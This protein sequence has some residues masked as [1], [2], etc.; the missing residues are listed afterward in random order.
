MDNL[1]INDYIYIVNEYGK[2]LRKIIWK[3]E[4][5]IEWNGGYAEISQL[6][7][8]NNSKVKYILS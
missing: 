1:K 6:K 3:N 4:Y 5:Y 8:N 7:E 2:F